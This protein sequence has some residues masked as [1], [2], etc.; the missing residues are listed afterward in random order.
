MATDTMEFD[1][2]VNYDYE[3]VVEDFLGLPLEKRTEES[4]QYFLFR[5][6]AKE[7]ITHEDALKWLTKSPV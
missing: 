5:L 2:P 4:W 6:A 7:I 1:V 3:T